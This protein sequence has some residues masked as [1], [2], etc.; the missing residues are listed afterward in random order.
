MNPFLLQDLGSIPEMCIYGFINETDKKIFIG[1]T[2][3]I[4]TALNRN[5]KEMKYSNHPCKDD[6]DKLKVINIETLKSRQDAKIRYQ[7]WVKQYSNQGY[8]MYRKY[9][10]VDYKVRIEVLRDFRVKPPTSAYLLYVKLLDRRYKSITV[11]VF[12][13]VSEAD[14]FV[15]NN[16]AQVDKIVYSDNQLT[17][18]Y[19]RRVK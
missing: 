16:Y 13:Q 4:V 15:A 12:D 7:Y 14:D 3:D 8:R 1:Y 2:T 18:E 9:K 5:L 11:G 10:A 17:K 19:L 6:F